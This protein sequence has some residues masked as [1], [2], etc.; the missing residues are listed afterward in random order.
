[1]NCKNFM[2]AHLEYS[3]LIEIIV[4]PS[5]HLNKKWVFINDKK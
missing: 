2:L 4:F 5:L 3:V 1:M